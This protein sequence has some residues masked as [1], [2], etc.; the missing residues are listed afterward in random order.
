[1]VRW[2]YGERTSLWL[3]GPGRAEMRAGL[4]AAA[5]GQAVTVR[6]NGRELRRIELPPSEEFA[7]I[8][9]SLELGPGENRVDMEYA[10]QEPGGA[11]PGRAV[12]F[13]KLQ[14]LPVVRP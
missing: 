4:R 9:L 5:R 8:D 1:V 12:L 2:G 6:L 13:R 7:G 11:L 3:D 10:A 14:I